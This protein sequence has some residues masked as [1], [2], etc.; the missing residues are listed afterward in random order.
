[1]IID[2]FYSF[3]LKPIV[4]SERYT[5]K[6]QL[7]VG[8]NDLL[9]LV[10]EYFESIQV[11]KIGPIDNANGYIAYSVEGKGSFLEYGPIIFQTSLQSVGYGLVRSS[12]KD[13]AILFR[14]LKDG[15]FEVYVFKGRYTSSILLLQM[16]KDGVFNY[17]IEKIKARI[18]E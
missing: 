5:M 6:R 15:V 12:K 2:A 10:F 1:M 14:R 4:N 17:E 8:S 3:S 18:S 7:K 13:D 16:L 9:N 11:R